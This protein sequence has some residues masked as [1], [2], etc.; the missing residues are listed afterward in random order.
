MSLDD[1]NPSKELGIEA[2]IK[3][4]QSS[5]QS[6]NEV[7]GEALKKSGF[8]GTSWRGPLPPQVVEKI[9]PEVANE[10]VL[11]LCRRQERQDVIVER[12]IESKEQQQRNLHSFKIKLYP[13]QNGIQELRVFQ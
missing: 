13:S 4:D 7:L 2:L 5:G 3:E 11:S 12:L 6:E 9:S 1:N 10:M 8:K